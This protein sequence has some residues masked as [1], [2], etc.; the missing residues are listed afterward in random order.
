MF[1]SISSIHFNTNKMYLFIMHVKWQYSSSNNTTPA[2]ATATLYHYSTIVAG[3]IGVGDT[4]NH[5]Q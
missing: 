2:A 1:V 5:R 4:N 3:D